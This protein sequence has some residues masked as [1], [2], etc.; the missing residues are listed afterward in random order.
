MHLQL[1]SCTPFLSFCLSRNLE[2]VPNTP[3][4]QCHSS[5][6][7][8]ISVLRNFH[9]K[10]FE[11]L[12]HYLFDSC[13]KQ[14]V[15]RCVM[16]SAFWRQPPDE[17]GPR[18]SG[19]SHSVCHFSKRLSIVKA[20]SQRPCESWPKYGSLKKSQTT[21]RWFLGFPHSNALRNDKSNKTMSGFSPRPI[22][23]PH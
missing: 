20:S 13:W 3:S 21:F 1:L 22:V 23:F 19:R 12:I 6:M 16:M 15:S 5:I 4:D 17:A 10:C 11:L 14:L 9:I 18:R 7:F 8:Y 2:V